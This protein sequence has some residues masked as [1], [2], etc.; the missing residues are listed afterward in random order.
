M[1]T[2]S[3]TQVLQGW[4]ERRTG[5]AFKG[6]SSFPFVKRRVERAS[7]YHGRQ[8]TG[9]R[10]RG[11]MQI[12]AKTLTGKTVTLD[13]EAS[14]TIENVKQKIQDKE[15]IPPDQQ[16]L[17]FAGKQLE[18]GRT[19]ADY[20]IEE[21]ST[22]Y[23]VLRLR[24]G[25]CAFDFADPAKGCVVHKS[26]DDAPPWRVCARGL[27]LEARCSN[28]ACAAHGKNVLIQVG[29]GAF[30][31]GELPY[32]H[33]CCPECKQVVA[34]PGTKFWLHQCEF[35]W[36]GR[37]S[38]NPSELCE[39]S[40]SYGDGLYESK[41]CDGGASWRSLKFTVGEPKRGKRGAGTRVYVKT[42][43]GKTITL[44]VGGSDTVESFKQAIQDKEGIPPS[45]QR[46][47]FAGRQLEDRRTLAD[48]NICS[49][50]TLHLVLR[51]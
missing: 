7:A 31:M 23:L 18:D 1:A 49:E 50:S 19:L 20:N 37:K 45:K 13:V 43:T 6:S 15:G 35:G 33:N 42:L 47:I 12:F 46:L 11:G 2:T 39:G 25:G 40:A 21:E 8:R 24:G 41:D 9:L 51:M 48:Y 10:L 4:L 30:D 26:S 29:Y 17:I 34:E 27:T 5:G 44:D 16:R 28:K 32:V 22:L 3:T 36:R 38:S 14:D